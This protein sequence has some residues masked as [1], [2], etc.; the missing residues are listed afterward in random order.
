MNAPPTTHQPAPLPAPRRLATP[1][2]ARA[3]F[4]RRELRSAARI[5]AEAAATLALLAW[6]AGRVATIPAWQAAAL[7]VAGASGMFDFVLDWIA[8]R[9]TPL[10]RVP[11]DACYGPHTGASIRAAVADVRRAMGLEGRPCRVWLVPDKEIN[12]AALRVG[13]LPWLRGF[14]AVAI[15][16]AILHLLDRRELEYVIGHEL[17]HVFLHSPLASRCLALHAAFAGAVSLAV[18]LLLA[19]SE[20]MVAAPVA[21]VA[22]ARWIAFRTTAADLQRIEFL[23][24]EAGAAVAGREAA[25]TA[26]LKMGLEQE[27]RETLLRRVLEAKLADERIPMQRLVAAYEASLPYGGVVPEEAHEHLAA[28]LGRLRAE[29]RGLSF[30][31]LA[32][33]L[34]GG[35]DADHEGLRETLARMSAAER[36]ARVGPPAAEL[37]AAPARAAEAILAAPDRVLFGLEDEIHDA[38][39][40]HP[41][42]SRRILHLWRD[43]GTEAATPGRADG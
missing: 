39:L 30:R 17:G 33:A 8:M 41:S 19:G 25:T 36:I 14:G 6:S 34:F 23:C 13:L 11:D 32:R 1:R 42:A 28:S 18:G 35:D 24:D 29:Q 38:H 9:R 22:A 26:L 2:A 40:G 31:G 4:R 21:G 3:E 7:F 43:R 15:N 5:G 10:G 20:W 27:A 16:R 37:L 12:A